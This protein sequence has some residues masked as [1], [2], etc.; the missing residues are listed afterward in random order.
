MSYLFATASRR[1]AL[2]IF[3]VLSAAMP[4]MAQVT[5]FS[6]F[7]VAAAVDQGVKKHANIAFAHGGEMERL[8]I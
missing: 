4:A 3:L 5:I 1:L 6:A 2:I 7:N 8:D